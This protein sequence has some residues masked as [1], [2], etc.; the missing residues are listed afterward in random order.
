MAWWVWFAIGGGVVALLYVVSI[1]RNPIELVKIGQGGQQ[2]IHAI[3]FIFVL[4]AA[5]LGTLLW[6]VL[7]LLFRL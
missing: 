6:L 2:V 3:L 1:V 4:G 7:G 5:T